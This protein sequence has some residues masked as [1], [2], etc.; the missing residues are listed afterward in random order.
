MCS[1]I[2]T[3]AQRSHL[4]GEWARDTL[5]LTA[6]QYQDRVQVFKNLE[7]IWNDRSLL[8]PQKGGRWGQHNTLL[9]DDS[10]LKA[11][12]QPY[13]HILI[14]E[15]VK[16]GE[17][18]GDGKDVFGKVVG[19]LEEARRYSDVSAFGRVMRFDIEGGWSWKWEGKRG[20]A[21][22]R[23]GSRQE[24]SSEQSTTNY[25]EE[26]EDDEDSDGGVSI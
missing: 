26:D 25:E 9:I 12:A 13:N 7:R 21:V 11:S 3:P 6:A 15:F 24:V 20:S 2:F 10:A 18:E 14:P 1:H 17:R 8:Q 5:G 19:Y 22:S 4:L 23:G 16:G